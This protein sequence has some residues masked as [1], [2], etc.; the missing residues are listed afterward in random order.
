MKI[1]KFYSI[2][3]YKKGWIAEKFAVFYL[4]I[5]GYKILKTRYKSRQGEI[6]I[7][8]YHRCALV[9]LEVKKRKTQQE[10]LNA[11]LPRQYERILRTLNVFLLHHPKYA[12]LE[13]RFDIILISQFRLKHLKNVWRADENRSL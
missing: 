4:M 7:V 13:I 6:D 11:I 12:G 3:A 5:K 9:V 2:T 8:A 1:P 10:A